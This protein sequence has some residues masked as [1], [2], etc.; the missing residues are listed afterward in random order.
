[1]IDVHIHIFFLKLFTVI[2][3]DIDKFSRHKVLFYFLFRTALRNLFAYKLE[4]K[5]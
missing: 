4:K 5:R 3:S 1:M 2:Y